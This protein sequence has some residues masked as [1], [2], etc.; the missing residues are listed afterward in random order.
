MDDKVHMKNGLH[1]AEDGAKLWYLNGALHRED[2]PAMECANGYKSW[3]INGKRHRLD[4]PAVEC[5][6]YKHWCIDDKLHRLDGPAVERANGT[7]GWYLNGIYLGDDVVGFWALWK[8]LTPEQQ[9]DLN[10][11]RWLAKYSAIV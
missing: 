5:A 2:G 10:L 6:H 7:A 11:H 1:I 9:Y 8:K 4:G 3:C